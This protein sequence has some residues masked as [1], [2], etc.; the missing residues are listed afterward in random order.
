MIVTAPP[1]AADPVPLPNHTWTPPILRTVATEGQGISALVEAIASHRLHLETTGGW[2]RRERA[3]LQA[4]LDL[5][6]RERLVDCWRARLP[7]AAYEQAIDGLLARSL[8]PYQAVE[9]LVKC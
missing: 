9:K 8:S 6:L 4:E 3:R 1:P 5:L 7:E 2:Q